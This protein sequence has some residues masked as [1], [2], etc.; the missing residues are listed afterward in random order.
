MIEADIEYPDS[1]M[2]LHGDLPWAPEHLILTYEHLSPYAKD[3]CDKLNLQGVY[4]CRKLIPNFYP[5]KNY[6]THY[7]NS[8]FYVEQGLI[9]RKIH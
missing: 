3:L 6:I 7:L 2:D 4:P 9:I 1:C 5:K 8:K